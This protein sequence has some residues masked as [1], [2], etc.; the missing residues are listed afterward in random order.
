MGYR[1]EWGSLPG[2]IVSAGEVVDQNDSTNERWAL[3]VDGIC[4]EGEPEEFLALAK[5]ILT[6]F[7]G[8][9]AIILYSQPPKEIN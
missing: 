3:S 5:E 8:E 7:R 2:E 4:I 9:P 1:V 6:T